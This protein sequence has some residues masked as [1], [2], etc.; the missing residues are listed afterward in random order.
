M[1]KTKKRF[2]TY[3]KHKLQTNYNTNYKK[4]QKNTKIQKTTKTL[5]KT[6][7]K[8]Q[9]PTKNYKKLQKIGKHKPKTN[10]FAVYRDPAPGCPSCEEKCSMSLLVENGLKT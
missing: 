2:T 6:K 10:W 8:L 4:L 1:I 7:K 3:G 5:Q 9:K